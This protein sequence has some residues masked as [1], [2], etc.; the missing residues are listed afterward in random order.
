M[1]SNLQKHNKKLF[2]VKKFISAR[3]AKEAIKLERKAS[4]DEIWIDE[5]WKKNNTNQL[6]SSIGF[7]V[8]NYE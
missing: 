7:D 4:V 6:P 2:C 1:T 3:S 5:E 8:S